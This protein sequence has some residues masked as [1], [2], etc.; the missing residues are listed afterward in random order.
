MTQIFNKSEL[1]ERRRQL[2]RNMTEPERRLW[3]VLRNKQLDGFKFR[4]QY[5]VGAYVL[6]FY[7]PATRLAIEIDGP[8]HDGIEAAAHDRNRQEEIESLGIHFLRF[9]N[10]QVDMEL[11]KVLTAIRETL[12]TC[13]STNT[14][15]LEKG[16]G[17][18]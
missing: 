8:Y 11:K 1:K 6:D 17:R 9:T 18:G 13:K 16:R 2:R 3:Q 12:A 14:P 7:C 4:R 10:D 5:S 15:P